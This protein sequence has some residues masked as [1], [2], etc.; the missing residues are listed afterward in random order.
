MPWVIDQRHSQIGF[1]IKHMMFTSV[2]GIFHRY[3]ATIDIAPH[4]L[5]ASHFSGAIE[6]ASIDTHEP[7][8]DEH[9]RSADFFDVATYPTIDYRSTKIEALGG[10]RFRVTGDLTMHGVTRPVVVEG[11]YAGG[12]YRDPDGTLRTGF[13]AAGDLNR[14]DFGLTWNAALET[15]GVLVGE[16]VHVQLDVELMWQEDAA[17]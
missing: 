13:S 1:A 7:T 4:D 17:A 8:R 2:R 5:V 14:K 10:N 3:H 6:V 12:P 9:L 16:A 11:E 15:G